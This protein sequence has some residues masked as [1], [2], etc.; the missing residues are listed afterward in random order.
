ML[1]L[2]SKNKFISWHSLN[3]Q[4]VLLQLISGEHIGALAMSENEAGSDVVNMRLV[5]KKEGLN[6]SVVYVRVTLL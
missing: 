3:L 6:G 4:I 5:A 2:M 1:L